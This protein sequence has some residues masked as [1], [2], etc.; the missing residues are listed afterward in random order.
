MPFPC[1]PTSPTVAEDVLI[2]GG[3]YSLQGRLAYL[4]VGE[5]RGVAVIAGPHPLLGG[6]LDNN[7]VRGVADGLAE[8]GLATLRFNYRGVGRSEGPP[9][10]VTRHLAQFWQTSHV[11]DEMDLGR[12]VEA[13]VAWARRTVG[14]DVPL[15]LIG[16]S[17]GCALLA[18]LRPDA[19]GLLRI[20]IAP[21]VGKHDYDAFL[22]MQDPLLVIGSEDDFAT[23]ADRLRVWFDRL[24]APAQ[25]ILRHLDN[26]FFRGHERWL[27]ETLWDFLDSQW[28]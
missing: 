27:A 12:D 22:S 11:A 26:H 24:R 15:A 17:F 9:R 18:H 6:D 2:S 20:L 1:E 7:V 8:R 13:A 3:P 25:L 28:R 4:E 5:V 14:P 19:P 10:D 23:D 16:Y 21:T